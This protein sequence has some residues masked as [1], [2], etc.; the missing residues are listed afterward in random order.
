MIILVLDESA[1]VF[2]FSFLFFFYIFPAYKLVRLHWQLY[3]WVWK[4]PGCKFIIQLIPISST[5]THWQRE[6]IQIHQKS[7]ILKDNETNNMH[8]SIWWGTMCYFATGSTVWQPGNR[9]VKYA[10]INNKCQKISVK[11]SLKSIP[12]GFEWQAVRPGQ[13]KAQH[14]YQNYKWMKLPCWKS[15]KNA[16]VATLMIK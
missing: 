4:H 1:T 11:H 2:L 16:K 8:G 13:L 12:V 5:E 15:E 3:I 9:N 6:Q 7:K 10:A 14:K